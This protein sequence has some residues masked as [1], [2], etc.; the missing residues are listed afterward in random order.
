MKKIKDV[1]GREVE[2]TDNMYFVSMTDRFLSGWGCA[3][4]KIAKRV[5]IC[6]NYR[7]AQIIVDGIKNC[8]NQNG[9]R[10]VNICS[11]LPKYGGRYVVSYDMYKDCKLYIDRSDIKE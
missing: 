4:G 1:I 6:D 7:Q 10:Y 2:I 5:V 3:E 8:R 11:E 9:M